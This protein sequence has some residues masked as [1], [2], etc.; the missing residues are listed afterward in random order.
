MFSK[1]AGRQVKNGFINWE[2]GTRREG[3]KYNFLLITLR[4][5]VR[6]PVVAQQIK[7]MTSIHEDAGLI[8]G[9]TQ[10]FN[11]LILP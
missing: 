2:I 6:V 8:L 1:K 7:N 5:K 9:L 10:W 3:G 11:N 4:T